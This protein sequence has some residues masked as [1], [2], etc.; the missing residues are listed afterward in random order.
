ML[1]SIALKSVKNSLE[2][3]NL[4]DDIYGDHDHYVNSFLTSSNFFLTPSHVRKKIAAYIEKLKKK[5]EGFELYND[6]DKVLMVF[7]L[8]EKCF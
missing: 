8:N 1:I 4:I 3:Q 6:R 5:P 7:S 2:L